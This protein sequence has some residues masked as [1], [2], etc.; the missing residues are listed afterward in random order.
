MSSEPQSAA[1]VSA[2]PSASESAITEASPS[3]EPTSRPTS[4]ATATLTAIP[5]QSVLASTSASPLPSVLVAALPPASSP[6]PQRIRVSTSLRL[7]ITAGASGEEATQL[8]RALTASLGAI[9]KARL[10]GLVAAVEGLTTPTQAEADRLSLPLLALRRAWVIGGFLA[11]RWPSAELIAVAGSAALSGSGA[12][13][14][15]PVS[16]TLLVNTQAPAGRQ[17][18][19]AGG[20]GQVLLAAA[21]MLMAFNQ[22]LPTT[23]GPQSLE[24]AVQSSMVA[25]FGIAAS[26]RVCQVHEEGSEA[27]DCMVAPSTVTTTL[28]G[29]GAEGSSPVTVSAD[30]ASGGLDSAASQRLDGSGSQGASS[31]DDASQVALFALVAPLA[32]VLGCFVYRA[33]HQSVEDDAFEKEV[34]A[35][36]RKQAAASSTNKRV[37]VQAT[38]G[39]VIDDAEDCITLCHTPTSPEGGLPLQA[40]NIGES[41]FFVASPISHGSS[42]QHRHESGTA[43]GSQPH[44]CTDLSTEDGSRE[45]LGLGQAG[46]PLGLLNHP[47]L[48]GKAIRIRAATPMALPSGQPV[49]LQPLS[50][51]LPTRMAARTTTSEA[52]EAEFLAS[53]LGRPSSGRALTHM[54]LRHEGY[55]MG[56]PS[57][58][59]GMSAVSGKAQ[60]TSAS[61]MPPREASLQVPLQASPARPVTLSRAPNLSTWEGGS[62]LPAVNSG[63]S[64][65]CYVE[66]GDLMPSSQA[67]S[68]ASRSST[69]A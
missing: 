60:A 8:Q 12:Q 25:G 9:L 38:A 58:I 17:L 13:Q 49:R 30:A 20:S 11:P 28:E 43:E 66:E 36:G 51:K 24:D 10:E 47:S 33:Y 48:Q 54:L 35:S 3:A 44:G 67:S 68:L 23:Q 31:T 21:S 59:S 65:G 40:L 1:S 5:T 2:S 45:G 26:W 57:D 22:S 61:V 42:K 37:S 18:Q 14:Y 62:G 55:T 7:P 27:D 29:T 15:M 56:I 32:L 69:S 34:S 53:G 39:G 46:N 6:G 41:Q 4:S 52:E 64:K 16:V 50:P 19:E 63:R